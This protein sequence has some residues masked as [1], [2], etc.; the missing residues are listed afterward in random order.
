MPAYS[1]KAQPNLDA[2]A[3]GV[4]SSIGF[5]NWIIE[6]TSAAAKYHDALPLI[7]EQRDVRWAKKPTKQPFWANYWCG[8]DTRCTCRVYGSKGLESDAI[9]FLKNENWRRLAIH[10][11]FKHSR[12]QFSFGQAACYP[13]RADCFSKTHQQRSTLNAHEDW[14]TVIFCD[15]AALRKEEL[16][17]FDRIIRHSDA[18]GYLAGWPKSA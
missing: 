17:C 5:R 3:E 14:I 10:V 18:A 8:R 9:F 15:D 1:G 12:E 11:E 2:I 6:G 16:E 7:D 13:L 4:F